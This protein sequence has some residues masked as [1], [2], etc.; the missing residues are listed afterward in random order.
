M[1]VYFD[2]DRLIKGVEVYPCGIAVVKR[3]AVPSD[4]TPTGGERKEIVEL[5]AKAR[6]KMLFT[7]AT[8]LIKMRSMMTL[9]YPERY[10]ADGSK[11]K[12]HF[13]RIMAEL[14]SYYAMEMFWFLEFQQRGAPHLHILTDR[15]NPSHDDRAFVARNW[16]RI[17]GM[18]SNSG[19]MGMGHGATEEH[20]SRCIAVHVHKRG[21][22]PMKSED[23]AVRYMAKYAC[24]T[25]Q[26]IVP[27]NY[28]NVGRFW[29]CTKFVRDNKETP[30][31]IAIT[32]NV[33]RNVLADEGHKSFDWDVI[34][35][36]LYG[37]QALYDAA[38]SLA[39]HN[40]VPF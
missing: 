22:E 14:K 16:V 5:T 40:E 28:R 12:Y 35:T 13:K 32:N 26:K 7:M 11:V 31:E 19:Y 24:K 8:S 34:P 27:E 25:Y 6:Q 21:W 17:I 2:V 15:E 30:M 39:E 37:S 9:T 10:P 18:D 23:G 29:G 38:R 33:L 3:K 1:T 4:H 20:R 36:Y